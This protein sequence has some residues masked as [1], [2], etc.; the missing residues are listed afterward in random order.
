MPR[1]VAALTV[2]TLVNCLVSG[3]SAQNGGGVY[4]ITAT[5]CLIINNTVTSS[6][7]GGYGGTFANCTVAGNTAVG[8]GG[9][10]YGGSGAWLNNCI[11]FF[12]S[13]P[14]GSNLIGAKFNYTCTT[15]PLLGDDD[16]TNEPVFVDLSGGDFYLQSNSPCI[17]SGHNAFVAVTNDLDGN[18]R[19]VG[20]T[21]D[22]GAY[23]Y[24]AP[25]SVPSYAW[26]QQYGIPTDG[27]ADYANPDGDRLNN[28][29]EEIA[30][31]DPTNALSTLF[32]LNPTNSVS[33]IFLRWQ[34][35]SGKAYLIQRAT[36]LGAMPAFSTVTSNLYIYSSLGTYTDTT[37]TNAGPYFYRVGVQQ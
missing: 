21:V 28:Y 32:M 18:P 20:G 9:G 29:Q 3:N 22:M 8:S 10:V 7:G 27:S 11:V 13:A 24:Q 34:S 2:C 23:E 15:P 33:G 14:V 6:G 17:N 25:S 37:A 31:T 36:A 26:A 30:G 4:N 5:N 35:V 16:I 12:N 19:I 1:P